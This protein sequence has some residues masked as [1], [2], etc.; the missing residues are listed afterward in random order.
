MK[1][2]LLALACGLALAAPIAAQQTP[3][4]STAVH[5]VRPGDTLWDLA[6]Q[7]L[8]N[9]YLW[10][11]IYQLNRDVIANPNWIYPTERIRIPG[12]AAQPGPEAEVR[13]ATL[14]PRTVFFP[15]AEVEPGD[16]VEAME[17]ARRTAV[18][19]GDFYRAGQLVRD[20]EISPIGQLAEVVS[21]TVVPLETPRAIQ[22]YDR[23]FMKLSTTNRVI[24]G[25]RLQLIRRERAVG[26]YGRIHISSGLATVVSIQGEIATVVIDAMHSDVRPGDWAVPVTSFPLAL[27]VEPQPADGLAGRIV[28]FESPHAVHAVEDVAFV[29]LGR[30]SGVKE[31]D[32][33]VAVLPSAPAS[34]G[35]RPEIPI[36][37]LQ[38][39]RVSRLTAAV[40]VVEMEHPALVPGLPVRLVARMP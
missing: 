11:E 32:E 34:W 6:R 33:F 22:L 25:D 8:E 37:R 39:V 2:H 29:D 14:V 35:T 26:E 27:G 16:R 9:P 31:G 23:V 3:D 38:V 18:T 12:Q 13:D 4:D 7:Y 40:R 10:P 19:V 17:M 1:R 21:P 36:A 28:A 5:Q 30:E 24:E 20:G 15:A